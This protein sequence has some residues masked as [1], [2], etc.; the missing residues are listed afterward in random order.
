MHPCQ[1][2]VC[3]MCL[4]SGSRL[5]LV[6]EAAALGPLHHE[7]LGK[8]EPVAGAGSDAWP[9]LSPFPLSPLSLWRRE[10]MADKHKE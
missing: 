7:L 4:G 10:G 8:G 2:T 3:E 6:T 1:H 9:K 5:A